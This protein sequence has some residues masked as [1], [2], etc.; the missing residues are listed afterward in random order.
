M[1]RFEAEG[2]LR[3][4]AGPGCSLVVP[5]EGRVRIDVPEQR[6]VAPAWFDV[7]TPGEEDF[8]DP[9][10]GQVAPA[11]RVVVAVVPLLEAVA[12]AEVRIRDR[13]EG[14]VTPLAQ[15]LR[16]QGGALVDAKFLL[17]VIPES[18]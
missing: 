3:V 6:E 18:I 10:A 17:M 16:N 8:V 13:A 5:L 15:Q 9:A 12:G 7:A 1:L 4:E 11:S 2:F 14:R